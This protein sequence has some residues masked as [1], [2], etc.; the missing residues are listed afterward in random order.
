MSGAQDRILAQWFKE[1][2]DSEDG[3]T[4]QVGDFGLIA[5]NTTNF[6]YTDIGPGVRTPMV[7]LSI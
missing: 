3:G 1:R 6:K 2:Y 5:S 7:R 4:R